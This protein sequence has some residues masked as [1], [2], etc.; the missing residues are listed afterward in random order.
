MIP[1][2]SVLSSRVNCTGCNDAAKMRIRLNR[3]VPDA[4]VYCIL[5]NWRGDL[6]EGHLS[7]SPDTPDP[8][9]TLLTSADG[10]VIAGR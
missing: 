2:G 8:T 10:A 5:W 4:F 1:L 9:M 7:G 6:S 3:K